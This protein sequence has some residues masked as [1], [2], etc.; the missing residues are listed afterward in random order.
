MATYIVEHLDKELGEWSLIE[1][2]HI[3]KIVGKENLWFTNIKKEDEEKLKEFGKVFQ[4]SITLLGISEACVLDPEANETL[5][6]KHN[7][8]FDY[9]VFGGILGDYPAKKRTSQELTQR[10]KLPSFNI[11][12][13]QM[14]TDNAVYVVKSIL[15]G[16]KLDEIRFQ[17]EIEI[18]TGE[19]DSV[20]LPYKYVLVNEKPLISP[21]LIEYIKKHPG[22]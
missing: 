6:S 16:K 5:E 7:Q 4:E 21:E 2:K 12:K 11:G 19:K 10:V 20:I 17:D 3:S 13:E 22:F 8:E 15:E 1:Y 14:S 18:K 9:F